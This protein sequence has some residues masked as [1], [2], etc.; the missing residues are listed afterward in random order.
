VLNRTSQKK[1]ALLLPISMY[2]AGRILSQQEQKASFPEFA[3][4]LCERRLEGRLA[5][6]TPAPLRAWL[7]VSQGPRT[8]AA[9]GRVNCTPE[10]VY[11]DTGS[12]WL[13]LK[14]L[15][16]RVGRWARAHGPL[17][18]TMGAGAATLL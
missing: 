5:Y 3:N 17:N 11:E 10:T 15:N 18:I 14:K 9:H 7:R 1:P 16:K 12:T 4:I 8:E 13:P 6:P 2:D